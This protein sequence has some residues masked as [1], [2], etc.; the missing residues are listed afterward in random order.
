M[1]SEAITRARSP[2]TSTKSRAAHPNI[3]GP[4][5]SRRGQTSIEFRPTLQAQHDDAT[6]KHQDH[7]GKLFTALLS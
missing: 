1:I 5:R 2:D 7:R 4:K 6:A 3:Y